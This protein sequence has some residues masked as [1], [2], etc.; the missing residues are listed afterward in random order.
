MANSKETYERIQLGNYQGRKMIDGGL[1]LSL[2]EEYADIVF[3][4][5]LASF[6]QVEK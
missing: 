5:L 4:G 2:V 1:K 3:R 6:D